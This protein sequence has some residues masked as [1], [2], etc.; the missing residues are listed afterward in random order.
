MRILVTGSTG[1]VGRLAVPLMLQDGHSVTAVGRSL[2]RLE[3]LAKLGASTVALDL[4]DRE[5]V[6][7]AAANHDVIVNLATHVPPPGPATFR[8]SAWRENDRIRSEASALLTEVAREAGVELFIQESFAPIYPDSGDT[9][10]TERFP[11]HPVRYNRSVLDA[12]Q[13]ANRFA[14]RGRRGVVLRFG[15]FYGAND[16][17]PESVVSSVRRGWLPVFGDS[18]GYFSTVSH[19]NAA[20]AVVAALRAPSGAYN[21]VDSDPLTRRELG[22]TVAA[23]VGTKAP[24]VPPRWIGKLFGG[25]GDILSR[26][27]RVSNRKLRDAVNWTP[28]QATMRDGWLHALQA[29]ESS[30]KPQEAQ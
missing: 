17:F 11:L 7:R 26:S 4:F 5:A 30:A 9:W 15:F 1:V 20:S 22:R 23:I 16:P 18:D 27:L 12:E 25:I 14:G 29:G 24:K 13:S 19:A 28:P 6:V 2:D 21:I 10:I 3:S 8:R